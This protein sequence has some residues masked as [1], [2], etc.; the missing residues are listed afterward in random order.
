MKILHNTKVLK[1]PLPIDIPVKDL[2]IDESPESHKPWAEFGFD[3]T[4]AIDFVVPL[5]TP[6]YAITSGKIIKLAM[7]SN[8]GGD[9]FKYAGR[10]NKIYIYNEESSLIFAY[11]H[12]AQLNTEETIKHFGTGRV[13]KGQLLGKV[14]LTG[15]TDAPHLH[16][17]VYEENNGFY[18]SLK[19]EF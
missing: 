1:F 8:C 4:Y 19:I 3:D 13:E 16:F 11:R 12:L 18:T 5:G 15:W 7:D 6:V 10:D 17:V 9:D 14:A 2:I